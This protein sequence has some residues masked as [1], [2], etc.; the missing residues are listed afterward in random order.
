MSFDNSPKFERLKKIEIFENENSLNLIFSD[1]INDLTAY[2]NIDLVNSNY[3]ISYIKD[4][5]RFDE[6]NSGLYSFGVSRSIEK[7]EYVIKL[8]KNYKNF[9]SF[10]LLQSAYFLF[11]PDQQKDTNYVNYAINQ[12]IEYDLQEFDF[13]EEWKSF[14]K[15]KYPNYEFRFDK[16]LELQDNKLSESPKHFF[17][18]Y[19]RRYPKL[20][21]DDNLYFIFDKMYQEFLFKISNNMIN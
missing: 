13:I 2:L 5:E 6:T 4:I 17:F 10:F 9:F 18:E 21:F 19:I 16:F 11:I 1:L 15:E 14:V 8:F 3:K 7:G 20:D 12:F